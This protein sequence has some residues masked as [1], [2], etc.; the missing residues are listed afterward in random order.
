M[1]A[2]LLAL[3]A[4]G[5]V[6]AS[7][8]AAQRTLVS[9]P[10]ELSAA[11]ASAQP[12]DVIALAN[13]TWTDVTVVFR[14]DGTE[15]D[16]IR[17]E[18]ETPGGVVLDGSSSLRI[19]G[20]YLVV[21]GLRFEGG[22]LSQGH[23]VQFRDGARVANHSRLTNST[24]VGVGA[25]NSNVNTKWVS[26]YGTHNRVDH[27]Y[28]AGKTNLGTTLVVWLES[29]ASHQPTYHRIDRNHFGPRPPLGQNGGETIRIGT[30]SVSM[31]DAFVTVE[32]NLFEQCD[33]EIEIISVKSGK[34][35]LR[36]NTFLRSRGTLTLRH[37]NGSRVEGNVFLGQRVDDTGGVRI[38]GEDHVVVNNYFELLAGTGLRAAISIMNGVPNSPLN[39]YFQVRNVT[40]AHNTV[41]RARDALA[42]GAGADA[43]RTLPPENV[44]FHNN[45]LLSQGETI[46][47]LDAE[48]INMTWDGTL[49]WG[50]SLGMDEPPG[51]TRVNPLIQ[52]EAGETLWRPLPESPI[53]D[54]AVAIPGLDLATDVDGQSRDATPDIGA[55]ERSPDAVRFRPLTPSDVGPSWPGATTAEPDVGRSSGIRLGAPFPNPS[56]GAASVPLAATASG[57]V[58]VVV[59]DALGRQ[60]ATLLQ[61]AIPAGSRTVRVDTLGWPAGVYTVVARRGR[62]V[63][64]TPF[65]VLTSR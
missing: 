65:T 31:Q 42:V 5:V 60:V 15:A 4:L 48:P 45:V 47:D 26:L 53:L 14:A 20:E 6:S 51:A 62:D 63:A 23:L 17:L 49:Y 1:T 41:V 9:T 52:P 8:A 2:R 37:G 58:E 61:G 25:I 12:G 29:G 33:G 64:R 59:V 43:E 10:S 32:E 35:T 22:T 27:N 18:A 56:D 36:R 55:D 44:R 11:I 24:I 38:I 54:A 13:G 3:A 46:V 34:N 16:S 30:S 57:D 21:D 7:C 19:A 50:G 28:I 39:R 40:V